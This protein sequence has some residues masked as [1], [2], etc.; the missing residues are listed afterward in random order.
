MP[1]TIKV[2]ITAR[3]VVRYERVM[4]LPT[5]K[6]AEYE[7]MCKRHQNGRVRDSEW[8]NA[9]GDY[10]LGVVEPDGDGLTDLEIEKVK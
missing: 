8:E 2:R 3:E 4:E 5:A 7:A 6:F 1:D 9:F 10:L